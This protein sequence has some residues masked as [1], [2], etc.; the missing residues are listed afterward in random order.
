MAT[1]ATIDVQLRANTAQY[2]AAM[3]DAARVA[4]QN[5]GMIQ[6]EAK[7]TAETFDLV[8][9]AAVGLIS[10][11]AMRAGANALLDVTKQQQALTNSMRASIGSSEQ[12]ADALTFVSETAKTLGLDYQTAAEGFQ[13]LTASATANGVAMDQQKQLFLEV[14]RAA[15]AMQIAPDKVD[16]AMTALSQSFS[17]GRFQAEELRQQLAEAIPGVVPRFQKAVMEMTKGTDLANKSFDQL[18]QGGLLDTQRFLPAMTQSFAEMGTSWREAADS[19]QAESNRLGNAWRDLKLELAEGA[20]SDTAIAGIR[21]ATVALGGVGAVMPVLVPAVTALAA[22]KLGQ[23]AASWVQ[24]LNAAHAATLAQAGSAE[25][26]A[27]ALVQKTRAELVDTQ[28]TAARARAAYGGSIAADLAAVQATNAHNRALAAHA[29][30]SQT[31]AAASARL[32]TA[33][34]AALGFFGGPLGLA[35]VVASTAA[36]WLLFRDNTKQAEEALIDWSGTADQAITRFREMNREQKQFSLLQLDDRIGT[37]LAETRRQIDEMALAMSNLNVGGQVFDTYSRAASKLAADF[38]AGRISA[39]QFSGGISDLNERTGRMIGGT[40]ELSQMFDRME[41]ALATTAVELDRNRKTSAELRGEFN[42][43]STAAQ[44]YAKSMLTLSGAAKEASDRIRGAINTLP[45]EIERIGKSARQVAQLDVR[46]W[47]R[48]LGKGGVDFRDRS[49]ADVQKLIEEGAQYIRLTGERDRAQKAATASARELSRATSDA[50]QDA[51]RAAEARQK[52][53][54]LELAA[55][56]SLNAS[57]RELLKFEL[58]LRDTKDKSLKAR[59]SEIRSVLE[60]NVALE[61]QIDAQRR[62]LDAKLR[63]MAVDRQ[64]V[65]Y[66]DSMQQRHQRDLEAIQFGGNTAQWN[67]ILNGINDEF[68][69]QRRG[70]DQDLQNRLASIPLEDMIRRNEEQA[71][72]NELIGKTVI[73]EAQATEQAKRNFEELLEA[74]GDWKNGAIRAF[75]DYT[76]AA[77]D[78]AGRTADAIDGVLGSLQGTFEEFFQTGK[79]NWRGF[80]DD[81]NAELARF[82]SQQL[83]KQIINA[84]SQNGDG[85]WVASLMSLFGSSD[86]YTGFDKG[87]YTGHGARMQPAGVV[88]KGEVVWSQGDI[89]RAGGVAVVEAMRRGLRGYAD[90]GMV[91]GS[92]MVRLGTSPAASHV[93]GRAM[94]SGGNTYNISVPVEGRVERLDRVQVAA[95]MQRTLARA[96]RIS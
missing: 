32:A 65:D 58:E 79:F 63:A 11:Q 13:R 51:M 12:A 74:Q 36:S 10:V 90:G 27:A 14:S 55:G 91:G 34:K 7:R 80:L 64:I 3:I 15:T 77:E 78:I 92:S 47:Y 45:G 61:N 81:I 31:A 29:V 16:R 70:L 43:G 94:R 18:L 20:F 4:N 39:D 93:P 5:L 28:A 2:R 38:Q 30:A 68:R 37:G 73:A 9:R 40:G 19:L 53:Y 50:A 49:N 59:A 22:V 46:D 69:Q 72:Y 62:L 26:A 23:S 60:E 6:R 66:Q 21:A 95:E 56:D 24:G 41:G 48:E 54:K 75:A 71:R 42:A 33:G 52:E 84:G 89:S 35:F 8:K 85:S 25:Q 96:G 86:Q 87:G 17:K 1:A 82:F 83:V 57:R 67:S 88:H 76:A 44:N